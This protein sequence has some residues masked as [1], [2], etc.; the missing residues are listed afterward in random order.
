MVLPNPN[1]IVLG[2][3]FFYDYVTSIDY[4][5]NN[6]SF[7]LSDVANKGASISKLP[8]PTPPGPSPDDPSKWIW[9]STAIVASIIL[10]IVVII[11]IYRWQKGRGQTVLRPTNVNFVPVNSNDVE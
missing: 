11:V 8:D 1:A 9:I 4:D 10:L 6:Y 7:G 5:T 2:I 3:P